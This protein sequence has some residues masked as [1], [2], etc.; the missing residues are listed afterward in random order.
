ML[1]RKTGLSQGAAIGCE[2][3]KAYKEAGIDCLEISPGEKRYDSLDIRRLKTLSD[4]YGVELRSFHLRFCD[5]EHYDISNTNEDVRRFVVEYHKKFISD[6]SAVGIKIF[7]IHASGEP[8]VNADRAARLECAKKSL[9]ELAEHAEA[10]DAV[11][12]VENLPRTCLGNTSEEL[13]DLVSC[14][15][16]LRICFDTN[17]LL[18]E[19]HESFLK[20]VSS[21]L[22]TTHFS[23][24]D[25]INERHWL[26]GEGDIDLKSLMDTLDATGYY[27]PIVYELPFAAALNTLTR[28]RSL[29]PADIKL[30]HYQLESRSEL[31]TIGKKVPNLGM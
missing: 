29:T 24:Y 22:I 28:P 6:C 19:N 13:I 8:I 26:P 2:E 27:G 23:D 5:F 17:H 1:K 30:N 15:N 31:T 12:A 18:S 4:A 25:F 3:F 16:R 10:H 21:K 14:D 7:V 11:I 20:A 9:R